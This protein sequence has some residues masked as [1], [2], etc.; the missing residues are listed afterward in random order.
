[1]SPAPSL[2]EAQWRN[3]IQITSG[4]PP[5]PQLVRAE[6]MFDEPGEAL[7]VGAGAGRDTGYLLRQGWRVTAVDASPYAAAALR[8]LPRQR[9]LQVV[10]SGIEEFEP[11]AYD[12]VNA[13]FSLPFISPTHF[14]ATVR[15]L[16]DSVRPD[17]IMAATFFGKHD[18]WNVAGTGL[19]FSTRPDIERLFRGWRF[20]EL[21]ESDEDSH[22]ADGTPKHWHLFHL[23]ARRVPD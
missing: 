3:F 18:E 12:L 22:T 15:R 21:I 9:N 11:A 8:R 1:M 7:D 23:I 19:T 14:D 13:Q 17:G 16:R 4:R 6:E 2:S 5:W 10:I 20:I